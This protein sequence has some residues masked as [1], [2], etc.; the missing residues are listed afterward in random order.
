MYT[1]NL[2][3]DFN[4][5]LAEA[6]LRNFQESNGYR[7]E[8]TSKEIE[9]REDKRRKAKSKKDAK[10]NVYLFIFLFFLFI[11]YIF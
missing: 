8:I 6:M 7:T 11:H 2:D 1:A 5:V 3:F 10:V 9:K 4:D